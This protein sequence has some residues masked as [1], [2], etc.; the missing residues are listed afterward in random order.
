M[1]RAAQSFISR[2]DRVRMLS[3]SDTYRSALLHRAH[4]SREYQQWPR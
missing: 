2:F 1:L 4:P 3:R